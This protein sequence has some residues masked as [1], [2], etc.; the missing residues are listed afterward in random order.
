MTST[1]FTAKEWLYHTMP[2][3]Y[4]SVFIKPANDATSKNTLETRNSSTD[5]PTCRCDGNN[6]DI[7][8]IDNY[9]LDDDCK[10]DS[11]DM[12]NDS[13]VPMK[14][15]ID[16][17]SLDHPTSPT[18]IP[19]MQVESAYEPPMQYPGSG[20][21]KMVYPHNELSVGSHISIF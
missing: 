2:E 21:P 1:G 14:T 10:F 16:A 15:A 19:S 6:N 3:S 17:G 4:K 20:I 13:I 18:S 12:P 5:F 7:T 9:K 11:L 8:F